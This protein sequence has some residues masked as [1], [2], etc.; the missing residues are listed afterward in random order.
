MVLLDEPFS[1]LDES[2]RATVRADTIAVL[3]ETG[4]T[5]ILVT[6]DQTEALSVSDRVVVLRDGGVEQV[7]TPVT[8]FESPA[9]RFVASFMGDADF[10]PAR[11]DSE[12]LTCEI[13]T[14][15]TTGNR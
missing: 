4:T 8:V 1:S 11:S 12:G 5:A 7:D 15:S 14:V 13:G 3:R 6:H 10:L 2:L 9:T